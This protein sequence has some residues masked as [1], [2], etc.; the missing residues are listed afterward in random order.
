MSDAKANEKGERLDSS[1]DSDTL[2]TA[3]AQSARTASASDLTTVEKSRT[4]ASDGSLA[5]YSSSDLAAQEHS[6]EL[7][8]GDRVASRKDKISESELLKQQ[9]QSP[10]NV[11]TQGLESV[12]KDEGVPQEKRALAS[13]IQDMRAQSKALGAPT[14]ALDDYAREA[15]KQELNAVS[16]RHTVD[17]DDLEQCGEH[18]FEPRI[19]ILE[20]GAPPANTT[21][22]PDNVRLTQKSDSGVT[23]KGE[24]VKSVTGYGDSSNDQVSFVS[25]TPEPDDWGGVAALPA[26]RQSEVITTAVRGHVE[27]WTVAE[28]EERLGAL[29]GAT[30]GLGTVLQDL[31]HLTDFA[32]A[33]M[34]GD[35]ETASDL[36]AKA[37]AAV[38]RMLVGEIQLFNL[39]ERYLNDLGAQGDW[40]KPAKDLYNLGSHIDKT[41]GDL[42]AREQERLKYQ[43]VVEMGAGALLPEQAQA[44][45]KSGK[46]TEIL[47]N[48]AK[49]AHKTGSE[50]AHAPADAKKTVAAIKGFFEDVHAPEAIMPDGR[51]VRLTREIRGLYLMSQAEELG[52]AAKPIDMLTGKPQ[53]VVEHV[54][55]VFES[56]EIIARFARRFGI[57]IPP[58]TVYFFEGEKEAHTAEIAARRL[59]VSVEQLQNQSEASLMAHGLQKVN[60]HRDVYFNKYPGLIAVADRIVVERGVPEWVLRDHPGLFSAA[61][62]NELSNLRGLAKT[63]ES[64]NH[65]RNIHN[66]WN[67]FRCDYPDPTRQ[68][69]LN[70]LKA[71]DKEFGKH[72]LP[73]TGGQ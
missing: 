28:S 53:T 55:R 45:L 13:M 26:D 19:T 16:S 66:I 18:H 38:G 30:E 69:V 14:A 12:A 64:L 22:S 33:C 58:K 39:S 48:M 42:P 62:L 43:F 49:I 40:L 54:E 29:V 51:T 7:V 11:N 23:D 25:R 1:K 9:A 57:D 8:F 71:I 5:R 36:G 37:G 65:Y 63:E 20:S 70:Q 3:D 31:A 4:N 17:H 35:K 2:K 52:G 73:P 10:D 6:I 41:W 46:L 72:F 59:G 27:H 21:M 44:V 68:Q 61:E 67:Q 15:L 32:H 24:A 60:D 50:L 47:P 34:F 56:P